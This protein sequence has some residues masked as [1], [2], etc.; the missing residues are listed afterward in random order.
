[1][2]QLFFDKRCLPHRD[3]FKSEGILLTSLFGLVSFS[4]ELYL[5]LQNALMIWLIG[6]KRL[7]F[8]ASQILKPLKLL[9]FVS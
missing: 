2:N 6:S 5:R 8:L 1:M 9:W 4:F 7:F 3:D